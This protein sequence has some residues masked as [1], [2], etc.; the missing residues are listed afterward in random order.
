MGWISSRGS[1]HFGVA[2]HVASHHHRHEKVAH[3]LADT[4]RANLSRDAT[5]IRADS[6]MPL[7]D[8]IQASLDRLKPSD[9]EIIELSAWEQL[10][11]IEIA[12]IIGMK[13]GAVRVRLHR[14]RS[15]LRADLIRSG[16][17]RSDPLGRVG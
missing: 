16:Y 14:I 8:V 11:P 17:P 7:A 15:A 10:T 9:R 5:A 6:D 2:R 3:G 1:G 12:N 13:P 4:L